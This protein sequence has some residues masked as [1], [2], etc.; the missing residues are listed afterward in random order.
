MNSQKQTDK[1]IPK[2]RSDKN[3]KHSKLKRLMKKTLP[4]AEAALSI[5]LVAGIAAG[6]ERSY[7]RQGC[8]EAYED[9]VQD[10]PMSEGDEVTV[11]NVTVRVTEINEREVRYDF[12]CGGEVIGSNSRTRDYFHDPEATVALQTDFEGFTILILHEDADFANKRLNLTV[13]LSPVAD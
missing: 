8:G 9:F 12:L 1:H 5:G 4:V 7:S 6:C 2:S 3:E 11:G 10:R 13:I